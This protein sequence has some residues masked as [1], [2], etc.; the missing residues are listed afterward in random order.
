MRCEAL[1]YLLSYS[2]GKNH[3]VGEIL[4]TNGGKNLAHWR[5][6][7]RQQDKRMQ[8]MIAM[9]SQLQ[10]GLR[11]LHSFGFSHGDLKLE[12]ICA[13]PGKDGNF[14]FTLVDLG[15]SS[16]LSRIGEDTRH[17]NFR[18]NLLTAS[19]DHLNNRRAGAVDDFYS[20]LCVAYN[21]T[22]GSLPWRD[23]ANEHYGND[24]YRHMSRRRYYIA[25]RKDKG[26]DFDR[27]MINKGVEL[28]QLLEHVCNLRKIRNS[29]DDIHKERRIVSKRI[30][31]M[32]YANF[33]LLLPPRAVFS[34]HELDLD[35]WGPGKQRRHSSGNL[36]DYAQKHGENLDKYILA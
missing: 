13:R 25:I 15:V 17:K 19:P 9:I 22:F 11:Q 5:Q 29:L 8:F 27:E 26:E 16:K 30:F 28:R 34:R 3:E 7:I 18:G 1:P 33:S 31:E 24:S 35:S 32:D 10:E 6:K 14:K 36:S 23:Y 12:N 4:M 20:L 21:F 2:V